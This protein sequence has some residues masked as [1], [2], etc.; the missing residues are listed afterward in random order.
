ML[1][2]HTITLDLM[3]PGTPPRIQVKQGD[4]LTHSLKILLLCDG[5]PWLA[6]DDAAPVLRWASNDPGS[7]QGAHGIYDT[8]PNGVHA[9]ILTQNQLDFITVPQMFALPG[10]VQADIVFVQDDKTLATFNFE[11]YVNPAPADGTE[12]EAQSYYKV[13][14]LDQIN[15]AITALEEWKAHMDQALDYLE[16]EVYHIKDIVFG[17]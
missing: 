11:F 15:S 9:W 13:A 12:P 16:R 14:T 3:R 10:I 6:P 5:E 1:I 2:N 7:C 4:T 8:L 17:V